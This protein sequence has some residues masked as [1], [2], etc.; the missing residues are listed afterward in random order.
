VHRSITLLAT[1]L[2]AMG[3]AL[4]LAVLSPS[5]ASPAAAATRPFYLSLGDSYSIGYQPGIGGTS[6]YTG[7]VAGKLNLRPENFGCGGATTSSLIGSKGCADPASQDAVPYT[8][9]TQERA[10]LNFIAAHKGAVRLIT[11]SIGGNDF[12][13]CTTAPCVQAAMPGMEAGI[14]TLVSAVDKALVK[15]SDT[16]ARIIGL[17]YPD[18]DL[19]LYVYPH[20]PPASAAVS[21][22]KSSILAF[23]D[24]INPTL[25]KSYLSVS[26]TSFVDVTSAPY[27]KATRGDDTSLS[28][29]EELAPYGTVP[30]AVGEVCQLTYFC[31]QGNIHADTAG[32]TF[33]GSL[34]VA[35]YR[36]LA[37]TAH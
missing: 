24:L 12:D 4:S 9:I 5:A 11:I 32:Y 13:S 36:S 1:A 26:G 16:D 19:G 30:V 15:A 20:N 14:K 33:I 37:R 2:V 27:M 23:D 3:T 10:A 21:L 34:V 25:K 7:Y 35:Q 6:G 18:V 8:G 22:A 17:T 28:L 29:T 31:S